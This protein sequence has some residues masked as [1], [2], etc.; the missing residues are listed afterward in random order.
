MFFKIMDDGDEAEPPGLSLGMRRRGDGRSRRA[1]P[2][3]GCDGMA[4][5]DAF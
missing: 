2:A 1:I 3:R 4:G 5:L